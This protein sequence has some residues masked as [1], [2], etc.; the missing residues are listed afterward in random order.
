M[1]II[2]VECGF[3]TSIINKE[4]HNENEDKIDTS[5]GTIAKVYIEHIN[6]PVE[7]VVILD[8]IEEQNF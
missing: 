3:A 2:W 8:K 4:I 1:L 5:N 6:G 7:G